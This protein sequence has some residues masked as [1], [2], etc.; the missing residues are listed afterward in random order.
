MGTLSLIIIWQFCLRASGPRLH[1]HFTL[2]GIAPKRLDLRGTIWLG[3]AT[4][5]FHCVE[6]DPN[7]KAF[8]VEGDVDLLGC[9][10]NEAAGFVSMRSQGE[11]AGRVDDDRARCEL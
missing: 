10:R 11:I 8:T 7:G 3:A 2:S 5:A 9:Q 1:I 6:D 4:L